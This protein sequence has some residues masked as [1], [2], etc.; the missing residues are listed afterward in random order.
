MSTSSNKNSRFFILFILSMSIIMAYMYLTRATHTIYLGA[1]TEGLWDSKTNVLHP[2]ALQLFE[3]HIGKKVTIA[4]IYRGWHELDSDNFITELQ[5]IDRYS[6]V[7]MVSANPYYFDQC[8]H[9]RYSLYKSIERGDCDAFLRN[10]SIR[11]RTYGKPLFFRFAWEMN[12]PS[13]EWSLQYTGSTAQEFVGAWRH[14]HT[15]MNEE[16]VTNVQWV[17]CPQVN[18]PTSIAYEEIFPGDEYVDWVGLDGYNWGTTQS[19]SSWQNF[20]DVFGSSYD[21]LVKLAPG[22]PVMIAEFGTTDQGGDKPGWF[23][24]AL[25]TQIPQRFPEV[26][27]L[28]FYNEDRSQEEQSNWKI[29]SPPQTLKSIQQGLKDSRYVSD[30]SQYK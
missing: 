19:W 20:S 12:I 2:E 26:K 14:I 11:F 15:I 1:W 13:N 30:F 8:K 3:E 7:P 25:N 16:N 27:A 21:E 17:F 29:D 24:A 28:I 5:T 10:I 22:K 18:T 23:S 4:H 6:W 9:T